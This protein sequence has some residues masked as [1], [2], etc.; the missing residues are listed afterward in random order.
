MGTSVAS[1]NIKRRLAAVLLGCFCAI[2][3]TVAYAHDAVV[4]GS[5][6]DGEVLASAPTTVTLEFSGEPKQGFNTM[7]ISNSKGD[8]LVTGEPT[9]DGRNV[10]LAIPEN[11]TLTPDEYTIGFQITSSDGHSTRGK[12]TFTIAGERVASSA[13]SDTTPATGAPTDPTAELM[14]GPWGKVAGGVGILLVLAMIVM[15]LARNRMGKKSQES[16]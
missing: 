9:V 11:T 7:A 10:T 3:T 15:I 5:P 16:D 13:A 14:A 4:G 6:A 1:T 2:T 8:V 12:T